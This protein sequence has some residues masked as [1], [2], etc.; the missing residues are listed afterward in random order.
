MAIWREVLA[1]LD[2]PDVWGPGGLFPLDAFR[3]TGTGYLARCPNP[4]HPDRHP[5]FSMPKGRAFGH[6][7]ACGYRR[8]WIGF[9]MEQQ[10]AGPE[11]RG[12]PFWAALRALAQRAGVALPDRRG[13]KTSRQTPSD[14]VLAASSGAAQY[15][16]QALRGPAPEARRVRDYLVG[17]G[18][19]ESHLPMFPLGALDHPPSLLKAL[20]AAGCSPKD[21]RQTG[22]LEPYMARHSL[23]FIYTDGRA[24][25]GFKGRIP[26]PT[27]KQVK[28]AKGFGG[29]LEARSL[30]GLELADE[31]IAASRRVI[32][33]E[34]EFDALSIQSA[35]LRAK[36]ATAEL[37]ALGGTAKPTREKFRTLQ[38]LGAEVVYLAFDADSAGEGGTAQ[39]LP[40]A[41]AEGLDAL[42]LPMPEGIKDPDD[43]L[44][45]WGLDRCLQELFALERGVPG[46]AWLARSLIRTAGESPEAGLRLRRRALD[47]AL[48]V[49]PGELKAFLEPLALALDEPVER[50]ETDVR[51]AGLAAREAQRRTR[52]LAWVRE[53]E[54]RLVKEQS[55]GPALR[56]ARRALEEAGAE[57][58]RPE[59]GQ[60]PSGQEP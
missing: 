33:V 59:A 24:V 23:V 17:R 54:A 26:D 4:A 36:G 49:P 50:L 16:R 55:L 15:L 34:G 42:V 7:F 1:R 11:A 43:A 56:E 6:C 48:A 28:N 14:P 53:F 19:A 47:L 57:I 22:L 31:A 8:G 27:V 44:R 3:R 2:H 20:T 9:V 29:E 13:G 21:I 45:A 51:V 12:E 10:G 30:F 46:A 18:L 60:E 35:L 40:L 5:S 37:V 38:A 32:L 58:D 52:L 41:W 39:A 25:T